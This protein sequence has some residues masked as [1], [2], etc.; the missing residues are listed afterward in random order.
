MIQK[1]FFLDGAGQLPRRYNSAGRASTTEPGIH[2]L[3]N[4]WI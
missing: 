2:G 1:I 4:P 3:L